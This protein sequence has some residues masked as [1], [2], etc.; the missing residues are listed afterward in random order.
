MP[1]LTRLSAIWC[2]DALFLAWLSELAGQPVNSDDAADVVREACGVSSRRELD[3][4]GRAADAFH[5]IVRRPY[6]AW[7]DQQHQPKGA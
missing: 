3:T 6:L 5:T 1:G 4:N 7:R 2:R